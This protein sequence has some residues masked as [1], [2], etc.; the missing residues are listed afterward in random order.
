MLTDVENEVLPGISGAVVPGLCYK[1]A[2]TGDIRIFNQNSHLPAPDFSL[3]LFLDASAS[4][5]NRQEKIA[6]ACFLIA[7]AFR[8]N[9]VP[10]RVSTYKSV[11][12]TL[13]V[14]VLKDTQKT[15]APASSGS[16]PQAITGMASPWPHK[17]I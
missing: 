12:D 7:E 16:T 10:L 9:H 17:A 2:L 6:E 14:N 5:M 13:V 3:D 4:Q 11:F 8:L 1:P 15:T